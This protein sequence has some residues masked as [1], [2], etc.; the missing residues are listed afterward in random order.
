MSEHPEPAAAPSPRTLALVLA[1]LGVVYGDIGTSPLYA[2]RECFAGPHGYPPT[3]ENV[4]SV[5]SL[6]FWALVVVVSVKYLLFVMRADNHGEGGILALM[7]L[8][9]GSGRSR[10]VNR[11]VLVMLGLFGAALLYGDGMITPAIS[12]LSAVEGL[13]VATPVFQPYVIP[14]TIG[15]LI[16]LFAVQRRGTAAVG[17]VFGPVTL[18]WFVTIALLGLAAIARQPAV[19]AALAPSHAI[20]FFER[21]AV[22]G[23]QVLGAVFLVVT[24]GEALYA[25]MGHFGARPIRLTWFSLVLPA[26]VCNYFGQGALLL[27]DPAAIDNP[28]YRMVP[29]WALYPLVALATAA[30]VIASQA[31]IS[32]TFSLTRQAVQLGYCPRVKILHTSTEEIGQIYVPLVN[33]ILMVATIGLVIGFR[34]SSSLAAAYGVA[35]STTMVITTILAYVVARELWKWPIAVALALS[36]A[37]IVVDLAFFGANLLKIAHGGWFPLLVAAG[38]YALLSTWKR[39]RQIVADRLHASTM[40]LDKFLEHVQEVKPARVAGTGVFMSASADCVP[41]TLVH[42]LTFNRAL[43]D[44]LVLLTIDVEERPHVPRGER[45]TIEPLQGGLTRLVGHYGFMDMPNVLE[46]V[47]RAEAKGLKVDVTDAT[48]YL[49][50]EIVVVSPRPGMARWRE[51]LFVLMLRNARRAVDFF[52]IPSDRVVEL[53]VKVEL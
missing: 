19:L 53:G 10:K 17:A 48:F 41:V 15:I 31:V 39:G 35:V 23:A 26:L 22:A 9:A 21:H 27:A 6:V 38:V 45:V 18:V 42:H 13:Q 40:P 12:V 20:G 44:R 29:G 43:H 33:W 47:G 50:R 24:G 34:T 25:D 14:I 16:G 11:R 37:F 1:T 36:S 5:L 30:T 7:A 8:V 46:I 3:P 2:V 52:R 32:G 28:F 4:L 51:H 49:G